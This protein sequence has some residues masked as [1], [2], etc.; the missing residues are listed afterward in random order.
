VQNTNYSASVQQVVDII[1]HH[2]HEPVQI[3]DIADELHLNA[4]YLGQLF[5]KETGQTFSQYLADWRINRA[6]SLLRQGGLDIG[7]I[8]EEVGYQNNG[9]FYKVFKKQ[10]GVSPRVYREQERQ[11]KA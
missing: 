11:I 3:T 6:K 4:V 10:V 8:A 7:L 5:K 1:Q 9:Y 2:Y